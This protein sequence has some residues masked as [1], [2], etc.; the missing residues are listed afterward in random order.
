MME[1]PVQ[2][3]PEWVKQDDLLDAYHQRMACTKLASP[4][5]KNTNQMSRNLQL[6]NF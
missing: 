2:E 5:K 3:I 4:N 1:C 6:G